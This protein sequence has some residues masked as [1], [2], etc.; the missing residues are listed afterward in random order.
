MNELL[1]KIQ[2]EVIAEFTQKLNTG[3]NKAMN[4]FAIQLITV[5][6]KVTKSFIEKY[7]QEKTL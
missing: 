3:D 6:A 7:E 2:N 1:E 5:S 4:E